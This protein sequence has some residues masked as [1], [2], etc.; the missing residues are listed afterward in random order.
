MF[1]RVLIVLLLAAIA[2]LAGGAPAFAAD[3]PVPDEGGSHRSTVSGSRKDGER[4]IGSALNWL[5]RHQAKEGSWGLTAFSKQCKDDTC[6]GPGR[7]E[8]LSAATALGLLPMLAA[9]QTHKDNVPYNKVVER[10]IA[11]LIDHQKA[12]G[13]LSAGCDQQMYSH[14]LAAIALCEA[15][16]M[17][18]DKVL[19]EPAQRAVNF[20]E[21][22]QNRKTGG[23]RY[24]PGQEGDTSVL[25]WQLSALKSAELAGLRVKSAT[26]DGARKWLASV[27]KSSDNGQANGRFSYFPDTAPTPTMSA[28]GILGNMELGLPLDEPV[29]TEGVK[30]LMANLPDQDSRNI[31]YS[32]FAT[33]VI[34]RVGDTHLKP[35][36]N[37]HTRKILVAMQEHEGCAAGSWSPD[38]PTRD[39]WGPVGGRLM[40]TSLSCLTLEVYYQYLSIFKVPTP[41]S[42]PARTKEESRPSPA[43]GTS[44]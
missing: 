38:K 13:D 12:D 18:R 42:G 3:D 9:G 23:W 19:A 40:T 4:T 32:Y 26:L 43:P 24:H 37:N 30:Y 35:T 21:D 14:A 39:A 25:G 41:K 2:A 44:P 6:T 8:S 15:F 11:W 7:T 22:A 16:G 28:V 20:I 36:W 33:Q 5:A 17:T 10:A 34:Y 29:V 31:Y 27:S 1:P